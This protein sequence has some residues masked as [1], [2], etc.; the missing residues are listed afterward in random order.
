MASWFD[1]WEN[2]GIS[3]GMIRIT[4][5]KIV[6]TTNPRTV[7]LK[8]TIHETILNKMIR[9]RKMVIERM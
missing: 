3:W 7:G 6:E 2:I 9:V 8:I 4:N 1:L 5:P